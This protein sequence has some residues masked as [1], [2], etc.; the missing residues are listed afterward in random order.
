L[1]GEGR[2]GWTGK[3]KT[4]NKKKYLH[5]IDKKS[6]F[7]ENEIISGFVFVVE[8]ISNSRK[9]VFAQPGI[10]LH[11]SFLLSFNNLNIPSHD[12]PHLFAACPSCFW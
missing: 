9:P 3:C 7:L 2:Q 6:H 12:Y 4:L 10:L 8:S 5:F 11:S 1:Q